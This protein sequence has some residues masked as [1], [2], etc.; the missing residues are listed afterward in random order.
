[1]AW[2]E[3]Q[4]SVDYVFGLAQNPRLKRSVRQQRERSR[5]LRPRPL[6]DAI[7]ERRGE[8]RAQL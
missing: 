7:R 1:M 8:R 6:A 4:E 5:R 2:C 3:A